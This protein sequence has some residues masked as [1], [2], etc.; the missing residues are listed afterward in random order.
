MQFHINADYW[1]FGEVDTAFGSDP[2]DPGFDSL[3][4]RPH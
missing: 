4:A 3:K 2:K 1:A